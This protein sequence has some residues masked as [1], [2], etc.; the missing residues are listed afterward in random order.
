[1]RSII[2]NAPVWGPSKRFRVCRFHTK[3]MLNSIVIVLLQYCYSWCVWGTH[4]RESFFLGSIVKNY[5]KTITRLLHHATWIFTV[6]PTQNKS[7]S[8]TPRLRIIYYG[9]NNNGV[10]ITSPTLQEHRDDVILPHL[11][12]YCNSIP[13]LLQYYYKY[14]YSATTVLLN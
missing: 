14:Y 11:N 6:G 10:F 3:A 1:M 5:Y 7:L 13:E 9:C 8:W 2:E 12:Y 4:S